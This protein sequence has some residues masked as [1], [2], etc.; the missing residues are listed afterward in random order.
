MISKHQSS[1]VYHWMKGFCHG[2]VPPC[3]CEVQGARWYH[4]REEIRQVP[5][6]HVGG[7]PTR[8]G[9]KNPVIQGFK[10]EHV[11]NP[12]PHSAE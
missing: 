2:A 1:N 7:V 10:F 9:Y 4:F 8:G 6:L 12:P 3:H 5:Y 11:G